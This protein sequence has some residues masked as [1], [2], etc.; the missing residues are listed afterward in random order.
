MMIIFE[1]NSV[2]ISLNFL[3][4]IFFS[5]ACVIVVLWK[6]LEKS[7]IMCHRFVSWKLFL[8]ILA[9]RFVSFIDF[10]YFQ[11]YTYKVEGDICQNKNKLKD[12]RGNNVLHFLKKG[13]RFFFS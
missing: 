9:L 1:K 3:G 4:L 13:K 10:S 5:F 7:I 11:K 12:K 6:A 2:Y 8:Y